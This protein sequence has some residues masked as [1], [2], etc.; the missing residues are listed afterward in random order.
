MSQAGRA[1]VLAALNVSRETTARLDSYAA[2][3]A[4]WNPAINLVAKSTLP[5]LWT[6]HILDSAQL[7][8]LAPK[9]ARHWADLGSGG[10]FPGLVIAILAAEKA[11]TLRVTLV[12]SDLRKATFLSTVVR[13]C[14]LTTTVCAERI[15]SLPPLRA[16]VLTAR[17]LAPLDG[18]LAH[19]E[20]HLAEGGIAIFPKGATHEAELASA[21]E[22]WRFSVQKHPSR[23]DSD[24]VLLVIG[25]IARA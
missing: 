9:G 19:A 5:D 11:P 1:E 12:E 24:A 21:L 18:L 16:D 17:A 23:T 25:D 22:H 20:R 6:R 14:G 2:L 4:K 10:G 8:D 7:L 3:L 13:E 15:E